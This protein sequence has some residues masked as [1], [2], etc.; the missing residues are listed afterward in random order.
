MRLAWILAAVLLMLADSASAQDAA[1]GRAQQLTVSANL[2]L[3]PSPD[4]KRAVLIKIIGGREQLFTI[5]IDGSGEAQITQD[6]ADHEDPAWSPDG[7]KIAFVLIRD[8]K[9][10]VHLVNPDGSGPVPVTPSNQSVIHPSFTPD[11]RAILYCTDDDLRP[12]EKNE[13]QIYSI[14]LATKQVRTLISGGV[15]TFPVMSPDGRTIAFRKIIGDMNSEIFVA[16]DDGSGPRNITNQWT[17]EGWPA[18]SPDGKTIAFAGNRNDAG[19]Q[20]FLM[21]PDG[22]NVRLL[23]NTEGRGTAP[24]WSADGDI[25]YFTVCRRSQDYRGCEIMA[26]P[27]S[28]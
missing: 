7:R 19:Y 17:F 23:A 1:I 14:N 9:K 3:T 26:A 5:N 21:N 6:D 4:G 24:K 22:S 25:V 13:S 10:I 20:I 12:P 8:G 18:W 27:V 11:G 28:A 2:D 16:N 15:N